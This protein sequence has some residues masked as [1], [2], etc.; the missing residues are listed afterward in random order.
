MNQGLRA[1]ALE[2][3]ERSR[4][5]GTASGGYSEIEMTQREATW[6]KS[7]GQSSVALEPMSSQIK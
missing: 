6:P 4:L 5:D 3:T 2:G 1:F 7:T